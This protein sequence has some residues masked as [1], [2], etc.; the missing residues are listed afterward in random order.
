M[1]TVSG[2]P[3]RFTQSL[4][5]M[6]DLSFSATSMTLSSLTFLSSDVELRHVRS[7]N[8]SQGLEIVTPYGRLEFWPAWG[9]RQMHRRLQELGWRYL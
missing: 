4:F 1:W 8:N 6:R 2:W 5:L 3:R 9:G 7:L